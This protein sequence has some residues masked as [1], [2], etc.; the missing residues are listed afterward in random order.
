ME[1][2]ENNNITTG[3]VKQEVALPVEEVTSSG[4]DAVMGNPEAQRRAEHQDSWE[5]QVEMLPEQLVTKQ[6]GSQV[7][8]DHQH[9]VEEHLKAAPAL[10]P[11]PN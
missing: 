8:Q 9:L 6:P 2:I 7:C 11:G 5:Q 3:G 10:S 4:K 1:K